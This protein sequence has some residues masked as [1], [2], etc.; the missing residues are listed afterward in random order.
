M[1][2]VVVNS[3]SVLGAKGLEARTEI[4]CV[5]AAQVERKLMPLLT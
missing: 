2:S 4:V 1:E 5:A 3:T